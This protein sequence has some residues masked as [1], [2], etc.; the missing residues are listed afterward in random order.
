[1]HRNSVPMGSLNNALMVLD[2]GSTPT[3][4]TVKLVY[5]DTVT[6][7]R[8]FGSLDSWTYEHLWPTSRGVTG[9]PASTDVQN[10]RPE[11]TRVKS[12][13]RGLFYG[14]C[15]TVEYADVCKMPA[16]SGLPDDTAL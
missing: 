10:L 13:R 15:G 3:Q 11:Q 16:E 9:R 2:K 7:A 4:E 14:S 5:S 8:A 12:Y 6:A 1:M